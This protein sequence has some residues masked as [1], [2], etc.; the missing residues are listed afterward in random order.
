MGLV[1]ISLLEREGIM[2]RMR[3]RV[4]GGLDRIGS[5]PLATP[6]LLREWWTESSGGHPIERD[7]RAHVAEALA[8]MERAH[9]AGHG[10]IARGYSL[11]PLP[12]F[13]GRGWQAA[14]PETTGYIIPTLYAAAWLDGR[15]DLAMR[16]TE[17]ARWELRVQRPDGAIPAGTVGQGETPAVFN[18]GQVIFGWLCAF[19]EVGDE[20]FAVAAR[21]AGSWL[22]DHLDTDG[23]W[24]RGNSPFARSD[25]TL[26]N[27]RAA[28]ALVAAGLQL[29]E[30]EFVAAGRA[31]L[32]AVAGVQYTNGWFPDCCLE[33]PRSPLTHTLAYTVQGLLE[34]AALLGDDRL[35]E[36]AE[37]AA[38]PLADAVR[39][40]GLLPGRLNDEWRPEVKWSCLTGAAQ[41]ANVWLRMAELL[42]APRWTGPAE[43]VLH[44]L[45]R[46]QNRV[47]EDPGL[48][49]GIKG[50]YPCTGEYG[51]LQT[52][53]WATKFFIDAHLRLRNLAAGR[54]DPRVQRSLALA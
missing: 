22:T 8:W 53:S 52:L 7:D 34:G 39:A 24:R 49:G 48:R 1:S 27:A 21:R 43:A 41:M 6:E 50:S 3:R 40:D 37:R 18:T 45:K 11:T 10:G 36:A 29:D 5:S 28:W 44:F 33:D 46:T 26:Y 51:R 25:A 32:H 2:A 31:A 47:S 30:P 12:E 23:R 13:G 9:A 35:F 16:A 38:G 17:A 14:Y 54:P 4:Q 19:G 20:R 42:D 15:P